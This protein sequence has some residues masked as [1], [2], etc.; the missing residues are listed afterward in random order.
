MDSGSPEAVKSL[1]LTHSP[2]DVSR[3]G[4]KVVGGYMR[5]T[6]TMQRHELL[7]SLLPCLRSATLASQEELV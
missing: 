5:L 1:S 4:T 3:V 7:H 2:N 6:A